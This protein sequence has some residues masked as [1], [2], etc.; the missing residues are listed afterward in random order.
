MVEINKNPIAEFK[1]MSLAFGGIKANSNVSL[2]LT[3]GLMHGLIGP[4]GAGKSTLF[5]VLTGIYQPTG[6]E[7]FYDG[8]TIAGLASH[9]LA[10]NGIGRTF[11]NIRLFKELTAIENVMTPLF[12]VSKTSF[13]DHLFA[14]KKYA[15][16]EKSFRQKSQELLDLMGIGDLAEVRADALPYGKQ[17]KLEIA[18][19]LA[20]SP[21][22]LLLDEPAAG[23]NPTETQELTNLIKKIQHQFGITV[24]LIEHDMRLVMQICDI[25][26]VLD[27]GELIAQGKPQEVQDNPKVIEAYLGVAE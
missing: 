22:L 2:S 25:I 27:H 3:P 8:K 9:D 10:K 1:D 19:A 13:T 5:N 26:F 4:N 12:N 20:L 24:L 6:G 18:R 14:T 23:L 16:E 17:R 7:V 21:K 11:Q 15:A